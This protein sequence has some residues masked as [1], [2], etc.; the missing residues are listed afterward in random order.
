MDSDGDANSVCL[1]DILMGTYA[2]GGGT[3]L[4][5]TIVDPA[6]TRT[7]SVIPPI[8][9]PVGFKNIAPFSYGGFKRRRSTS[10]E[11][12]EMERRDTESV[13]SIEQWQVSEF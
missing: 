3:W 13:M 10:L 9:E 12:R 6:K 4:P 8:A 1:S 7:G 11:D 2:G 5:V